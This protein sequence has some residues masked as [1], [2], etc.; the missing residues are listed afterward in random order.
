[1]YNSY[2]NI[3]K[4]IL[5]L[6]FTLLCFKL[7]I[8]GRKIIVNIVLIFWKLWNVISWIFDVENMIWKF[9]FSFFGCHYIAN[10]S[11]IFMLAILKY[12]VLTSYHLLPFTRK[13]I[14]VDYTKLA[15]LYQVLILF[16]NRFYTFLFYTVTLTYKALSTQL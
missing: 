16:S 7:M 5:I 15:K 11:F 1:M 9:W 14:R 13:C 12:W 4:N 10:P 6:Q 3:S 2:Q 8:F